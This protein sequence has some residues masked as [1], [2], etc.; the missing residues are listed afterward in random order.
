MT[1]DDFNFDGT[2]LFGD[3]ASSSSND[4]G[5]NA[6]D[7]GTESN[8]NIDTSNDIFSDSTQ[9]SILPAGAFDGAFDDN[10]QAFQDDAQTSD[11]KVLTRKAIITTAVGVV[12]VLLV[13]IIAGVIGK[14]SQEN[15]N[16]NLQQQTSNKQTQYSGGGDASSII[17]NQNN[18]ASAQVNENTQNSST[19][20]NNVQVVLN[21]VSDN[22]SIKWIEIDSQQQVTFK[23]EYSELTFTVT[24]IKHYARVVDESDTLDIKTTLTGSISG[25][26]GTYTLDVP[27]NQGVILENSPE[28]GIGCTFTVY[29]QI[30]DYNGKRVI[31][32]ISTYRK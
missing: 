29:V 28:L 2:D 3:D 22:N 4:F 15:E 8:N 7:F 1:T 13:L 32:E 30:G 10:Q 14:K 21:S 16:E 20:T 6:S 23:N 18:T 25:M 27:Y 9:Q 17:N 19:N 12:G 11:N 26:P 31:G 5:F 24:D